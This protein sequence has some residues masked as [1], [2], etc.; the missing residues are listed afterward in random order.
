LMAL[1]FVLF[2]FLASE[3]RLDNQQIFLL[4]VGMLAAGLACAFLLRPTTKAQLV[5]ERPS[6]PTSI[7]DVPLKS[8]VECA[9]LPAY[10]TDANL[11]VRH[12]NNHL[13]SFIGA[14][15]SQVM[16]KHVSK[17]VERFVQLVPDERKQAFMD[18][19]A[20]VIYEAEQAPYAAISEVVDL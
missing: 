19:Q 3:G 1:A 4:S 16:D 20:K 10:A 13:L 8:L 11:I 18:R 2:A 17:I 12:C 5:G 14:Q 6:V 15:R 9:E 7:L